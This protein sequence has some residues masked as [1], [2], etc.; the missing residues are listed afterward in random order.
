MSLI[1]PRTKARLQPY[2]KI[3]GTIYDQTQGLPSLDISGMKLI[4]AVKKISINNSRADIHFWRELNTDNYRGDSPEAIKET[5]PALPTYELTFDRVVLY[6]SNMLEAFG[7][8]GHDI[9]YQHQPL[10]IAFSLYMPT[11]SE[12]KEGSKTLFFDGVWFVNNPLEF[13]I[14]ADDLKIVQSITAKARGVRQATVWA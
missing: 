6:E 5:Y 8:E 3:Y 14:D 12:G 1:I 10:S 11:N 2:I 4:A 13:D 7:F 9:L